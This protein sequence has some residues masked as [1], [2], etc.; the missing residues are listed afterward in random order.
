M[1]RYLVPGGT[2]NWN[3]ITNWS[4]T[5]GGASGASFPVSTDDVIIDANSVNANLTVNVGSACLSINFINGHTGTLTINQTLTV[6]GNVTLGSGMT[7][8]TS[9]GTPTLSVNATSTLTSNGKTWPYA[10]SFSVS[11]TKTL[12]DNWVIGGNFTSATN[13][14]TVNGNQLT[15]N[16]SMTITGAMTGTTSVILAGTGTWSGASSIS[17][18]LT[19]NTAGTITFGS[20]LSYGVTGGTGTLTYTAGTVDATTN[21]SSFT[22][23]TCSLN[24]SG[25]TF[26]GFS[27]GTNC[28]ITLLSD[29]NTTGLAHGGST[30]TA[31]YNGA[32]NINVSGN[33][34][35]VLNTVI[36]GTATL[37]AIGTG[38]WATSGTAARLQLTT[39]INTSGT[40]TFGASWKYDTGTLTYISGTVDTTT[41]SNVFTMAASTTLNTAGIN[42][43]NVTVTGSSTITL[44]SLFTVTGTLTS[45][46]SSVAPKTWTGTSGFT[47]VNFTSLCTSGTGVLTLKN[48]NTYTV[49][50]TI[51]ITGTLAAPISLVS[52]SAGNQAT[53]TLVNDGS[54]VQDIDFCNPTD[55]SSSAGCTLATYKGTLSNA[56]NWRVMPTQPGQLS[57]GLE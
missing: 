12:A 17:N 9:S 33:F 41:N 53:L 32:Y 38:S 56:T 3:S 5:S 47:T 28:V 18:N 25:I 48:G 19:I 8:T 49:T 11:S 29:L 13:T 24:V 55:I 14:Q 57:Y 37:N 31:V 6:S 15:V 10:V 51:T 7:I 46:V 27:T 44:N 43:F 54:C 23:F 4:A 45:S 2:G 20:S 40:I 1:A 50:G 52:A 21:N 42:W 16:G 30:A 34:S 26:N 36:S 22:V 35:A 39:N